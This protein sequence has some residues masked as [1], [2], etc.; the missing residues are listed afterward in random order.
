MMLIGI[1]VFGYTGWFLVSFLRNFTDSFY[2]RTGLEKVTTEQFGDVRISE[3]LTEE[4]LIVT[5]DFIGQRPVIF[6]K[7]AA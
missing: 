6:T 5:Y 4:V 2:D 3:V 1:A 7:Y